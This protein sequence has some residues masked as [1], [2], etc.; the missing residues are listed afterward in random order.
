M[1][2]KASMSK[3]SVGQKW[4]DL[5]S[6]EVKGGFLE[7]VIIGDCFIGPI[8]AYKKN[9]GGEGTWVNISGRGN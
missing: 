2:E 4:N 3:Y 6:K 9:G 8:G 7:E 1:G 5:V